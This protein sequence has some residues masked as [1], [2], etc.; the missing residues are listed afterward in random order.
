LCAHFAMLVSVPSAVSAGQDDEVRRRE[1]LA[2]RVAAGPGLWEDEAWLAELRRDG[3]IGE[4]LAGGVIGQAAAEGGHGHR[5]ERALNAEMTMLCLVTGSL[6]PGQ[7]YDMVLAKAFAEPG[8]PARPGTPVPTGP[9]FSQARARLGEQPMR[10]VFEL[11]ASRDD[12]PP[13]AGGTALGLELVIFDGTT[14]DLFNCPELAA[15]FGVPEGGAHPRLRL[16]ALLQAGTMRWKAAA[17]GGYHDGENALADQLGAAP[18]PGQLSLADRGFFS[19]DRWTRFPAT[20]AHLLWRV[21]NT[22][23]SVPFRQLRTLK[24]GSGL[25]LLRESGN[26]P[27]RRR[28][29]AGDKTLPRL[30]DTVARLACFTVLSRT[31]RG[32][33]KTAAIRVLTTLLDPDAFPAREIASLYAA[34]WQVETAF[35]HLKK[36]V[37]G[38]GRVLRG[39]SATLARQEAWAL[40]LVHNMIAAPAAAAAAAAGTSPAAVSFT[41]A[42]SLVRDHAAA[43]ACCPHCG[44]RPAT[45]GDP[46]A[47]LTAAIAGQPLNRENRKRTSGRTTAERRK[48]PTEETTYDIT[49]V[50]SNLPKAD[51]S[52]RT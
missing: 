24:D 6:F 41:A 39:R 11:D 30:P 10:R 40:P 44:K 33:A 46:L 12:G 20:G 31:R 2:A 22:A 48:W 42:L 47:L 21:K 32:R 13:A 51:T 45:A 34:R 37:R 16:V 17:I 23:R 25:V 43:D 9:A 29:D 52:P 38:A 50:P 8:A 18:G 4:L 27:G 7:G 1:G 36:T 35:L 26:M 14:L 15:E 19:M 49:I 3:L 5:A 28:K